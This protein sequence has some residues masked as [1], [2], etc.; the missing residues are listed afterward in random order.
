MFGLLYRNRVRAALYSPTAETLADLRECFVA[1]YRRGI[2]DARNEV[3]EDQWVDLVSDTT[4]R[5]ARDRSNAEAGCWLAGVVTGRLALGDGEV[6]GD[7]E[8]IANLFY[9]ALVSGQ[10]ETYALYTL[11]P[12]FLKR[13]RTRDLLRRLNGTLAA[14]CS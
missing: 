9:S 4:M 8:G 6:A 2:E 12:V 5:L 14:G 7:D 11:Q 1:G 10:A 3:V 13:D